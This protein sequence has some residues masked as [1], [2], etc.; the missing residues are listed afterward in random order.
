[1][2]ILKQAHVELFKRGPDEMFDSLPGLARFVQEQKNQSRDRWIMPHLIKPKP[3]NNLM[4]DLGNDGAFAMNDWLTTRK[5]G[6]PSIH[7]TNFGTGKPRSSTGS[8]SMR[9]GIFNRC[10]AMLYSLL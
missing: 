3:M 7:W 8:L 4:V 9:G 2:A 5:S 10:T 6:L 1:M